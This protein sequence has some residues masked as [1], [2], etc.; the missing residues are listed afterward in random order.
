MPRGDSSGPNR[1]GP[2]TGR[3][4]GYC[5]GYDMPGFANSRR[6][7]GRGMGFRGSFGRMLMQPV[8]PVQPIQPTKEQEKQYLEQDAKAL[9]EEQKLLKEE[10]DD[11]KKRLA[12]LE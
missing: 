6:G 11:I 4:L 2:R 3:G 12:E 7:F 5:N 8:Q 10:L 1:M 9:E